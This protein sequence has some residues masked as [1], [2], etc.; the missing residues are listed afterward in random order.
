MSYIQSFSAGGAAAIGLDDDV[1]LNL[2]TSDDVNFLWETADADAHYLNLVIGT[3]RNIIISEDGGVD[4]T[5]AAST[6]PTLWVH[7]A[8]ETNVADYI[9]FSHDQTDANIVVGAGDLLLNIA[10]ANLAPSANDGFALGIATTGEVSDIFLAT[11]AVI[12]FNAGAET[13]THS[14]NTLTF[15]GTTLIDIAAGIFELNDAVRF[16]TGVAIVAASYS[17][18]RDADGTNQLHLNVPTGAT[19]EFSVNDAVEATLSA[20]AVNFQSNTITTTGG[21]SLTGTWSDLG[22]VTTV[23]INGGTI[24]GVTI[25]GA[26]AGAITGTTITAGGVVQLSGNDLIGSTGA[27]GTLTIVATS[28]GTPGAI[29]A[30]VEPGVEAWRTLA[31]GQ[32][33]FGRTTLPTSVDILGVGKDFNGMTAATVINETDGTAALA[34]FAVRAALTSGGT[35]AGAMVAVS[36]GITEASGRIARSVELLADSPATGGLN[37]RHLGAFP[38]IITING[39]K[40]AEFISGGGLQPGSD[41]GGAL[42]ASGTA[43][44]DLFLADGSVINFNAGNFTATHS[45]GVLTLSG[46]VTLANLTITS[47]AA[48]WTNAGRTVADLGIVTTVDVN[49]GTVDGATIGAASATTIIGTTIDA[50]TDFTIGATVITDGVLTDAGGFQ[51]DANVTLNGNL[52]T[53]AGDDISLAAGGRIFGG[54]VQLNHQ[55]LAADTNLTIDENDGVVGVTLGSSSDNTITLPAASGN[56]GMIVHVFVVDG[57]GTNNAVVT[58]A[59]SDTITNGSGDVGNVTVTMGDT[60]DFVVLQCVAAAVWNIIHESGSAVA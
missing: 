59:G 20:T 23:D 46:D 40:T 3:S 43:F 19:F 33:V 38:V 24:D 15:G 17:V 50:T 14:A 5:H 26:V 44:S 55:T 39:T 16:D 29:I 12:N 1:A 4:W 32:T 31:T 45:A 18:G 51:V 30:E 28:S 41:D 22:I 53:T 36:Q 9:N 57:S 56:E 52:T 25:G 34:Q 58:R 48:N 13:I 27:A 37:I 35:F 47:F 60:A 10:G 42:G 8:D 2:G 7:S 11:G 21:G 6:N 54:G 49:G